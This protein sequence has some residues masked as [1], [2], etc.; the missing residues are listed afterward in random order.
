MGKPRYLKFDAQ[1]RYDEL[2]G[3]IHWQARY[4]DKPI[5]CAVKIEALRDYFDAELDNPLLDFQR[6]RDALEAVAED[7]IMS[8]QVSRIAGQVH[9]T[10]EPRDC[11]ILPALVA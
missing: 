5:Q 11:T 1:A 8:G 9:A 7:K 6:H 10:I 2:T 4:Y 3:T